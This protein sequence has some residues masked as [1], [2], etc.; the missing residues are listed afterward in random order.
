MPPYYYTTEEQSDTTVLGVNISNTDP[1]VVLRPTRVGSV[2]D[3]VRDFAWTVSPKTNEEFKKV[4]VMY[5]TE[6]EQTTNSLLGSALY[7]LNA[8]T[9]A[10]AQKNVREVTVDLLTKLEDL[11]SAAFTAGSTALTELNKYAS[12]LTGTTEVRRALPVEEP[13]SPLRGLADNIRDLA[14]NITPAPQKLIN[15][16]TTFTGAYNG[17]DRA[18][19]SDKLK[20]YFGIYLT[21]PTGFQ[22]A[23]P[24]FGN[25]PLGIINQWSS[26]AGMHNEKVSEFISDKQKMVDE[27]AT[28]FNINQPGTFI[29]KPKYYQYSDGGKTVTITFPLLNTVKKTDKITYQQN[30]ELLWI[31]AFQNRPY[32]TSFS[33]VSPPKLYT[34]T[35]PGQQFMPYCYISNM[36]VDFQGTRR[37]LPVS[38]GIT[39]GTTATVAVPDAYV[40]TLT[41][42][43]LIADV[44]NTMVDQGFT[45]NKVRA[46]SQ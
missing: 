27:I 19:V 2:I 35:I 40:V 33:R 46:S 8:T 30:Y 45:N 6:L 28:S 10:Q 16:I 12:Q 39:P 22:Y 34:L 3:V 4:P 18:L 9:G 14:G 31:L 7:Y 38:L 11:G 26:T 36:T 1:L 32:R 41:F 5:L 15:W 17:V 43:S 13:G 24:Y 44:G 20:S 42:T 29:E 21:K 37:N 23:L 25:S